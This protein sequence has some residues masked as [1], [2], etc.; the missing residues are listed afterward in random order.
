MEEIV[1]S[2]IG[3]LSGVAETIEPS[4]PESLL[5]TASFSDQGLSFQ[6]FR[7]WLISV[8][9]M[10][11]YL[12]SLTTEVSS[13]DQGKLNHF[14]LNIPNVMNSSFIGRAAPLLIF[15]PEAQN[16][17]ILRPEYGWFLLGML[18]DKDKFWSLAFNSSMD[19]QSFNSFMGKAR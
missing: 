14:Y 12:L 5:A 10:K 18:S 11:K 8:P 17:L 9:S 6:N 7:K 1:K 19:G 13:G 3:S 4:F 16:H 2:V 15:P